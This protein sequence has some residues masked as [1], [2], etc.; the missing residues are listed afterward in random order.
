[1]DT[2][3]AGLRIGLMVKNNKTSK[4]WMI[5]DFVTS[6]SSTKK[7]QPDEFKVRLYNGA[8]K[9]ITISVESLNKNYKW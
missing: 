9:H 1:M 5:T 3:F 7:Q 4:N 8:G 2:K 6:Y